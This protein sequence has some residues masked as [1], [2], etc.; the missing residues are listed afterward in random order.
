MKA[1]EANDIHGALAKCSE[2]RPP[3]DIAILA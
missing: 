2:L 3:V 1:F